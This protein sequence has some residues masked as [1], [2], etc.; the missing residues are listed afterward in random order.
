MTDSVASGSMRSG[1]ASA[2]GA[3]HGVGIVHRDLKP[4]NIFLVGDAPTVKVVD[5]GIAKLDD[6]D[7]LTRT[8][9]VMGTLAYMSPEQWGEDTVDTRT[10]I[11]A[12]GIV[13][14]EMVTGEHPLAPLS[15]RT[16]ASVVLRSSSC[17]AARNVRCCLAITTCSSTTGPTASIS[18]WPTR[19]MSS[20]R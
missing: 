9:A 18:G 15:M 6:D 17:M 5:F 20:S 19:A 4:G 1:V 16:L 12:V 8:G 14:F 7:R 2:L 3:A 10:D 11:W 13:L